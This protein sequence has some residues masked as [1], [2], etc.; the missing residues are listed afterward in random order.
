M[1]TSKTG[2]QPKIT[3]FLGESDNVSN[4]LLS[5][6][7]GGRKL[8]IGLRDLVRQRYNGRFEI[9]FLRESWENG[10]PDI[11][12]GKSLLLER[13][14][15]I[16]VFS[17]AGDVTT[18]ISVEDFK[19]RLLRLIRVVKDRLDAHVIVFN[20]CSADPAD[21][22]HNYHG[23][24]DTFPLRAHKFNL[25]VMQASVLEGIS[26]IDVERVIGQLAAD[27]HVLSPL[28]YSV[29]AYETIGK[30]FLRVI[31]DIAFFENRPLVMQVGQRG[32]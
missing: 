11:D 12:A 25:A 4:A 20:C 3:V 9:E 5:I 18:S 26:F 22:V 29:Q 6:E 10:I 27:T 7:E 21:N 15:G 14:P 19:T 31:E 1:G 24:P 30:E 2:G 28:R 16:V 17:A 13:Q 8:G 32:K 23:L